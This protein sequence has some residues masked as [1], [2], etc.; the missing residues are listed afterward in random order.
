MLRCTLIDFSHDSLFSD[1]PQEYLVHLNV[2]AA[3]LGPGK[4]LEVR[5]GG[6]LVVGQKLYSLEGDFIVLET[7]DG[8][9]GFVS[10]ERDTILIFSCVAIKHAYS[11]VYLC[12]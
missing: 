4:R 10:P 1:R 11:L 8:E 3:Q 7:L 12:A 2:P 5:P 9:V 6:R